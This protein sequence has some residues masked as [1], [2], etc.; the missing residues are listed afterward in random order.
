[1]VTTK[2]VSKKMV[3]QGF[4]E[5]IRLTESIQPEEFYEYRY[6]LHV[7]GNTASWGLIEK[8]TMDAV[9]IWHRSPVKYQEHYYDLLKPWVHYVPLE[10]NMSNLEQIRDWLSLHRGKREALEMRDRLNEFM[11]RRLRPEDLICCVL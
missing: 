6:H 7:D 10:S 11:R 3:Q 5:N 4:K 2:D 8:L 9:M 1:M